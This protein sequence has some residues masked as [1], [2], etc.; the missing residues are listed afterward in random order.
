[1]CPPPP[2]LENGDFNTI[3]IV[4]YTCKPYYVLTK[5]QDQY[6]CVDGKWDTPPKCL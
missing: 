1:T 3:T 6:K 4:S 2:Y 5:Q